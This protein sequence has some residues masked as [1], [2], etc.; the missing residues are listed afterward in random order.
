MKKLTHVMA[1]GYHSWG[2]AKGVEEALR[3]WQKNFGSL[4][5]DKITINL[6]AVSEDAYVDEM[7]TLYAERMEKLPDIVFTKSDFEA[8]FEGRNILLDLIHG[9]EVS[10]RIYDLKE[11]E[12]EDEF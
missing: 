1:V 9:Y 5:H 7:G 4:R 6:R 12:I 8:V 11:S 10:D 3:N 2:K